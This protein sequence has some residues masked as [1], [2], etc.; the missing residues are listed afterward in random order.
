MNENQD[1]NTPPLTHIQELGEFGLIDHLTQNLKNEQT[2]T[3]KAV[4]DDAAVIHY[5]KGEVI[6]ST[7]MYVEGVHFDMVYTPLMHLGYKCVTGSI[8]DIYA[9]NGNPEQ[10]LVSLALSSRFTVEAM[11]ELYT[12]IRI[13]CKT[14]GVDL[15]GGD[16]TS[17]KTGLVISVTA[18]GHA[19]NKD[20]C[21]RD[22]A[23]AGDIICVSGDLGGAYV[24]LQVLE[25]E[26]RVYLEAPGAQPEL[27][28]FDY[29]LKRQLR[30]EARKDVIS[31]L[32]ELQI[33]PTSMIDISDGLASEIMH[34]C[35]QSGTGCMLYE[36]KI[37]ID[38]NTYNTALKF[39][40]DPTLCALSGGEDY[41][42]LFTINGND[43]EKIKNNPDVTVIGHI[44]GKEDGCKITT[45]SGNQYELQA[46]GWKHF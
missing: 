29:V 14:Y 23:Q 32:K 43:Y 9:M 6:V 7:D 12:G 19:E 39:N 24:G 34:I 10:V 36:E 17:S 44:G 13:A 1:Q 8:S 21:Y 30:P 15:V 38:E 3:L 26:K 18:I 35:K 2:S 40:I 46:Q 41:E 11:D 25:R 31:I 5:D 28:G 27:S 22:G 37:P 16:T 33:K 42:L 45:K 4:G 20:I